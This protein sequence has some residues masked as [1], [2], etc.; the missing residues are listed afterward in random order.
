MFHVSTF[1]P[2]KEKDIQQIERKRHI[3]NDTV[4]ILFTDGNTPFSVGTIRSKYIQVF[5]V[6]HCFEEDQQIK[7]RVSLAQ[8]DEVPPFGPPLP[9]PPVFTQKNSSILAINEI[10]ECG[11]G[12]SSGS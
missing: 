5:V 2:F 4:V 6:V 8:R 9:D 1:L 3:G 12:F 10:G 7:Y 11:E